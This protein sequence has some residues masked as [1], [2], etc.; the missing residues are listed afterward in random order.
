MTEQELEVIRKLRS[1][2]YAIV[3]FTPEEL[4]GADKGAVEDRMIES[5]W[6]A[7]EWNKD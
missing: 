6:H 5:G 7:I 2:G 4:E 1:E 3:I